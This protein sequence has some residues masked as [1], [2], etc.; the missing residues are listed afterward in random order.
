V[1]WCSPSCQDPGQTGKTGCAQYGTGEF[2]AHLLGTAPVRPTQLA[3]A[4][5]RLFC[6]Q[7]G[8]GQRLCG[9]CGSCCWLSFTPW[10]FREMEGPTPPSAVFYSVVLVQAGVDLL[11]L[12][13]MF[14]RVPVAQV[15]LVLI[16]VLTALHGYVVGQTQTDIKTSL[17]IATAMQTGLMCAECGLG[18]RG[19]NGVCV[20]MQRCTVS[21]SSARNRFCTTLTISLSSH[22]KDRSP[23]GYQPNSCC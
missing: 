11:L 22:G 1:L 4:V 17:D 20:P 9:G 12:Q 16:G 7:S 21:F 19:C 23:V 2:A 14:E 5:F 8:T 6:A 13:A 10:L 15:L 3:P 18:L